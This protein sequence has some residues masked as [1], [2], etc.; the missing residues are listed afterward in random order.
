MNA[1]L[2][3]LLLLVTV[4]MMDLLASAEVDLFT[5]SFPELQR[6]FHLSPLQ[7][8]ALLS[9]NCI[10]MC[11]S[12]VYMGGL[13]DRYGRKPIITLGLSLFLLGSTL[14]AFADSYGL[15]MA[16]RLLQ[17]IGV[18]APATLSFLIVADS[19]SFKKQQYYLGVLNG[20]VNASVAAAPVVGSY[21]TLYFHWRGNFV[22]LWLLAAVVG[23]QPVRVTVRI[24][25]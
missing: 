21:I 15:L 13:A 7:V 6:L 3:P 12:L 1:A 5:P 8:E 17:G 16:G 25:A 4:I 11:L 22:A 2:K 19:F 24:P 18:A 20:I 9:I 10:G 14:C 23:I